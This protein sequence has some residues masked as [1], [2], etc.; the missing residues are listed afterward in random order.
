MS[1]VSTGGGLVLL[2]TPSLYFRAFYGVPRSVTAPDGTPV[3]A[4]RGLLDVLARQI[5]EL[6]PRHLV[7]CFDGDWRPAFRVELVPSYKAHRVA[8][9]LDPAGAA[10]AAPGSASPA[11]TDPAGPPDGDAAVAA[12]QVEE[13]PDE[14][15]PQL[16]VIDAMLDAFGIARVEVAGFEADDVIGTLA[17]RYPYG[18]EDG[19]AARDG[20]A[21]PV[22]GF[23]GPVEILTGDRDLFQ[24]VRD[25]VPVRVRYTV[26][27]FAVVDEAA[28]TA[29]YGVPGRAYGDFAVLRGDP[30][31]GLPGVAGIGAKT[32]AALLNRFGSLDAALAA[33]DA[34]QVDGFAAGARRRLEAA[35]DY[36]DSARIVVRVVPDV[37]LPPLRAELPAAPADPERVAELA[38]RWG[39]AGSA[40]R[41][42]RA[43]AAAAG[44]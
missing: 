37:P 25:D 15:S 17:T 6:R 8:E 5:V 36:L 34:G 20:A 23:T 4:V 40:T 10:P 35:R 18:A 26:D 21:D 7:C 29:R 28:V 30:S 32:A 19:W 12:V 43:L 44:G 42:V 24:L 31:D 1:D 14:L 2:D 33:L 9:V 3:N 11:A 16:P 38:A 13:V 22:G 27:K 41:L 39:L